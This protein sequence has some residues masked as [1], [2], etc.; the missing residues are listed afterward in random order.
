MK[1]L[2]GRDLGSA[3]GRERSEAAYRVSC[4]CGH[5]VCCEVVSY[6]DGLAM[7]VFFDDEETS[8]T[9]GERVLLCPG[10][11]SRLS[12]LSFRS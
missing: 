12:L 9:R 3:I 7:L 10:C 4:A 5:K 6:G 1:P 2:S 8:A 11:H